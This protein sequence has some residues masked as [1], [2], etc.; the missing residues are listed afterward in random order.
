MEEN[1]KKNTKTTPPLFS[2]PNRTA[3]HVFLQSIELRLPV[4]STTSLPVVFVDKR[5]SEVNTIPSPPTKLGSRKSASE[6]SDPPLN[7]RALDIDS[8][9]SISPP[10]VRRFRVVVHGFPAFSDV[11]RRTPAFILAVAVAVAVA[12]GFV[13]FQD[14]VSLLVIAPAVLSVGAVAG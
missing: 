4:A 3:R 9:L 14:V 10:L 8:R 2:I 6:I 13:R 1:G 11:P 5:I 7:V 12:R